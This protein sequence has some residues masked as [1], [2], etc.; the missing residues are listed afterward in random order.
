MSS[1]SEPPRLCGFR[2]E[3]LKQ[4]LFDCFRKNNVNSSA[5]KIANLPT[6]VKFSSWYWMMSSTSPFESVLDKVEVMKSVT[7]AEDVVLTQVR[8]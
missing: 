4:V 6:P 5:C 1:E 8:S 3:T 2:K 7:V